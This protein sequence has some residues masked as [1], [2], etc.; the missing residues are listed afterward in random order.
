MPKP[1]QEATPP[2]NNRSFLARLLEAHKHGNMD[3]A[4]DE[5]FPM[6]MPERHWSEY[7]EV[8]F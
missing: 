3:A 6:S 5:L 1:V 2:Q 7:R 4:L 8:P